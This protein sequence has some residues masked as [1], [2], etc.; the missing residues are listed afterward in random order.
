MLCNAFRHGSQ[1]HESQTA[2][3]EMSEDSGGRPFFEAG[4]KDCRKEESGRLTQPK[5]LNTS[6]QRKSPS[7]NSSS[8][9]SFRNMCSR[10]YS[11]T[12]SGTLLSNFQGCIPASN[13]RRV[14]QSRLRIQPKSFSTSPAP[15]PHTRSSTPVRYRHLRFCMRGTYA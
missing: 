11:R 13:C 1:S 7:P 12:L 8:S 4:R 6:K 5:T 15:F 3:N 10:H 2:F 9:L 14:K